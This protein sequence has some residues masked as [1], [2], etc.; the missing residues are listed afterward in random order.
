MFLKV[1]LIIVIIFGENYV[2]GTKYIDIYQFCGWVGRYLVHFTF[3][4]L[5]LRAKKLHKLDLY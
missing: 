2:L 1:P 4:S 3:F 5:L